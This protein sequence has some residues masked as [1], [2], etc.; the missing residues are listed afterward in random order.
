MIADNIAQVKLVYTI[1]L[2][3]SS[4]FFLYG[5]QVDFEVDGTGGTSTHRVHLRTYQHGIVSVSAFHRAL[6]GHVL[7]IA[8]SHDMT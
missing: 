5:H 6:I 7:G 4:I 2:V 3:S 8:S 1:I